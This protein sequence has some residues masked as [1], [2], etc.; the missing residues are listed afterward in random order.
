[1]IAN[2]GKMQSKSF[3]DYIPKQDD[4]KVD[5]KVTKIK[6]QKTQES[7][8]KNPPKDNPASFSDIVLNEEIRQEI[9]IREKEKIESEISECLHKKLKEE[10]DNNLKDI[11]IEL[12]ERVITD[13]NEKNSTMHQSLIE[14]IQ[15]LFDVSGVLIERVE[16]LQT[17]LNITVPTPIVQVAVPDRSVTRK[18]HRDN[19]GNITHITEESNNE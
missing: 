2:G 19:Q 8:V 14:A 11:K 13:I 12:F 3:I 1:M 18:I 7:A 10:Y 17:S 4:K 16:A 15:R 5:Q 9:Y 6:K